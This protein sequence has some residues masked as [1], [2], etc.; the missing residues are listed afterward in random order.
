MGIGKARSWTP[1]FNKRVIGILHFA[2][3][4]FQS[5]QESFI[6]YFLDIKEQIMQDSVLAGNNNMKS[7]IL[8]YAIIKTKGIRKK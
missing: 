3:H 5:H 1:G 8:E 2:A 6:T 4:H 7:L